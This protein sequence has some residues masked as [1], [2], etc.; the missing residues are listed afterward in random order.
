MATV[1]TERATA[2]SKDPAAGA[3]GLREQAH[4]RWSLSTVPRNPQLIVGA[5]IV[6]VATLVAIAA[7][8]LAPYDPLDQ[9]LIN[10][11]ST[12]RRIA[13]GMVSLVL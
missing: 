2:R 1:T 4:R 13:V 3:R 7:P 9:D 6:L 11:H 12:P 10:R 5:T 8:W